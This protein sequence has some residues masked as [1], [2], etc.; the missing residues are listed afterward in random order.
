MFHSTDSAGTTNLTITV[1]DVDAHIAD[2]ADRGISAEALDTPSGQFRLATIADP[3]GNAI[4]LAQ[5][6][7]QAEGRVVRP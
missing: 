7:G 3:A 4:T 1:D 2:L 5:D 6:I